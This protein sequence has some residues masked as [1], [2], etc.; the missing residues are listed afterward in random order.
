MS[1]LIVATRERLSTFMQCPMSRNKTSLRHHKSGDYMQVMDV[2]CLFHNRLLFADW[3]TYV[4]KVTHFY[5]IK[6][7][8]IWK[9]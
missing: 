5:L 4:R 8:I 6:T 9:S 3:R 7:Q 2:H 1:C